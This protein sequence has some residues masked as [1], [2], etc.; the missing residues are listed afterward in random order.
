VGNTG[1]TN[2]QLWPF[3]HNRPQMHVW[4]APGARSLFRKEGFGFRFAPKVNF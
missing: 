4:E 3:R 2:P 1:G